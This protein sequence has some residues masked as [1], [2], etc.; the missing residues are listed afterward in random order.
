MRNLEQRLIAVSPDI[1]YVALGCP[2]QERVAA[3]LRL[4]LPRTW[5]LGVGISFSFVSG[6]VKRAPAWMRKAGL[7]WFHRMM[8]EP[9]R[10]AKRYL[11]DGL[12][13]AARLFWVSWLRGWRSNAV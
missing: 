11:V 7:E 6:E 12:P 5:F 8:Q 4:S 9:G 2:K 1:M 10:L 3:R 13:F